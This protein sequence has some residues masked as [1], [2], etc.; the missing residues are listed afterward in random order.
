MSR[1][2]NTGEEESRAD[3]PAPGPLFMAGVPYANSAAKFWRSL[4]DEVRV[5]FPDCSRVDLETLS[6]DPLNADQMFPERAL[7]RDFN[8]LLES[9]LADEIR[10][11]LAELEMFGA[12]AAVT[13]RLA[14][15]EKDILSRELPLDCLDAEIF[16]CL[17][18]WLLQW[19]GVAE[20][21]W[22]RDRVEGVVRAEDRNRGVLYRWSFCLVHHPLREGLLRRTLSLALSVE[23][24]QS[25][26]ANTAA[27]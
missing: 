5:D 7:E 9:N 17:L 11:T 21:D 2:I 22:N 18:V 19:A 15:P 26:T 25:G 23:Q 24:D 1:L 4:A 10:K 13:I 16:S 12:P 3:L 6:S 14:G 27:P 20:A 8:L